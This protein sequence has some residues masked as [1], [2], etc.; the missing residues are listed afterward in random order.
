MAISII[1]G[2]YR[3]VLQCIVHD[4]SDFKYIGVIKFRANNI[5]PSGQHDSMNAGLA[6]KSPALY[7]GIMA[8][9]DIKEL[10]RL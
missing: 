5:M 4:M 2:F 3:N 10:A 1:M 8:T 9:K 6:S 7:L